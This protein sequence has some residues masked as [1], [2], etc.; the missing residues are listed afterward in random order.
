MLIAQQYRSTSKP[1]P[2]F[3][4]RWLGRLLVVFIAATL[5]LGPIS[6]GETVSHGDRAGSTITADTLVDSQLHG[7]LPSMAEETPH[8]ST[9]SAPHSHCA[10]HCSLSTLL[11]SLVFLATLLLAARLCSASTLSFPQFVTPPLSPPPQTAR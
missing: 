9:D 5:V 3:A 8:S 1:Q 4:P 10:L 6:I 7:V 11:F 2:C